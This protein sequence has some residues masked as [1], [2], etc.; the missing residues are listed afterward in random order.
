MRAVQITRFGG[1]E[2]MDVVDLP[3]PVPGDGEQLFDIRSGG[4]DIADTHH[5]LSAN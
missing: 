5:Q 4:V 2:V 3:D 1:P